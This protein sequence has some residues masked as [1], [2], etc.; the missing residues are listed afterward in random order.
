MSFNVLKSVREELETRL[1]V[2]CR[3]EVPATRPA[4]FVTIERTGGTYERGVDRPI[5]AVQCWAGS[6]SEA[7]ALALAAREVLISLP[8]TVPSVCRSAVDSI[9][10]FP[11][12]D[13]DMR[14]YQLNLELVT[15]P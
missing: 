7:Y 2:P 10:D 8:E 3:V 1:G 12:P 5:M 6:M 15:R 11:D 14:R 13:S 9:Y 4:Q